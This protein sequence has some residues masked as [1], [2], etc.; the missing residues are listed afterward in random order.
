MTIP[1]DEH[2]A[3]FDN[4]LQDFKQKECNL[5]V[6]LTQKAKIVYSTPSIG[7]KSTENEKAFDGEDVKGIKK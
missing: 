2:F 6:S 3:S 1:E 4:Q 7:T 5:T